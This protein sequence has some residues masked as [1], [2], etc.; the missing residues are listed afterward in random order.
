MDSF[1]APAADLVGQ[2]FDAQ[3]EQGVPAKSRPKK[4]THILGSKVAWDHIATDYTTERCKCTCDE[5]D[6]RLEA[7]SLRCL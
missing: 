5:R 2:Q 7:N 4:R 3:G 1:R 6:L